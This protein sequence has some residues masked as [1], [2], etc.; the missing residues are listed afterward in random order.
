M[1][2][3]WGLQGPV[4]VRLLLVLVLLVPQPLDQL[5]LLLLGAAPPDAP[6]QPQVIV[7]PALLQR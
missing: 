2:G 6:R 1:R 4:Q 3:T 7:A 5:L